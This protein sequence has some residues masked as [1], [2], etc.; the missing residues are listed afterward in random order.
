MVERAPSSR[1]PKSRSGT[2]LPVAA[3]VHYI[4]SQ[5]GPADPAQIAQRAKDLGWKLTSQDIENVVAYLKHL[6][7]VMVG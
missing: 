5:L 6:G 4:V 3:K 7:L 2:L 1:N